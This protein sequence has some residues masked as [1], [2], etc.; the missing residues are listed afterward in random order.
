MF[1][2]HYGPAFAAKPLARRIP[3][4]LLFI[5]VQ[6]MD[7]CWSVLVMLHVEKLRIIPGFTEGSPLDLY[8]MPFT[9]GL[10]GA[11]ALAVLF[12]GIASSFFSA[13]RTKVFFVLATAAFSHWLFDLVVHVPDLPLWKDTMKVGLGLWRWAWISVP[14]ELVVMAG[15]AWI[16]ARFVPAKKGGDTWLWLFVAAMAALELYNQFAPPPQDTAIMA[17]MALVAY[18]FLA[19]LAAL[20]DRT[21]TA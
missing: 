12:G 15:G 3:L 18:G 13:P 4:W 5:A 17:A 14:L 2:G 9:H 20:V 19:L 10:L 11:L 1:I 7:V 21:R 8:Y 6:W 16:Y